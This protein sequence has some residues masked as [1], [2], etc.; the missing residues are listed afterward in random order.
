[1]IVVPYTLLFWAFVQICMGAARQLTDPPSRDNTKVINCIACYLQGL[2]TAGVA[3][4]AK[5]I[6]T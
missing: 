1:M 3:A 2:A 6:V 4:I 5:Y